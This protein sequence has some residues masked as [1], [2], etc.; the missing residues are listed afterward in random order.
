M[1]RK[2]LIDGFPRNINNVDAWYDKM[3]IITNL[4]NVLYL[5]LPE[6]V[7]L[8]R[9]LKRGK[10]SGRTDDNIEV[11]KKRFRTFKEESGQVLELYDS[12]GMLLEVN[13]SGS[14][15]ECYKLVKEALKII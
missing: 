13:G 9:I 5:S 1:F 8:K 11:A 4:E 10:T 3:S 12:W 6:D 7:M 14:I 15:P 2:Y